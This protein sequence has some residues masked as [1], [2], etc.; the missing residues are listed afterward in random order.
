MKC[1][2]KNISLV[3]N[4]IDTKMFDAVD[5]DGQNVLHLAS[6]RNTKILDFIVS[7][8]KEKRNDL[9]FKKNNYGSIFFDN[10]AYNTKYRS[11]SIFS[12]KHPLNHLRFR[13][14]YTFGFKT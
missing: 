9:F 14:T 5:N 8:L 4:K 2:L 10:I 11:E 1:G 13:K 6:K 12:S 7:E 3:F